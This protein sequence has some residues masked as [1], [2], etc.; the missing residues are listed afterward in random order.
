MADVIDLNSRRPVL[1]HFH[2]R[3]TRDA[4]ALER[5][6]RPYVALQRLDTADGRP[7]VEIQFTDGVWMLADPTRDLEPVDPQQAEHWAR[8]GRQW[9]QRN[10]R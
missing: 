1:G 2:A 10:P 7:L 4:H 5:D 8:I 9:E 6:G 3:A